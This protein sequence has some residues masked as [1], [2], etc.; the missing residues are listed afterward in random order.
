MVAKW[1]FLCSGILMLVGTLSSCTTVHFKR[2]TEAKALHESGDA[3]QALALLDQITVDISGQK[4]WDMRDTTA[5]YKARIQQ[6]RIHRSGGEH[7]AALAPMEQACTCLGSVAFQLRQV[8]SSMAANYARMTIECLDEEKELLRE[9]GIPES[10]WN[11]H[12]TPPGFALASVTPLKLR[13]EETEVSENGAF[14]TALAICPKPGLA[15]ADEYHHWLTVVRK[16][17]K[18]G[19]I[20]DRMGLPHGEAVMTLSP[21]KAGRQDYTVLDVRNGILL[22][23]ILSATPEKMDEHRKV[24]LDFVRGYTLRSESYEK[25][26]PH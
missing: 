15:T 24:F 17:T 1:V 6:G 18:I 23:F 26:G 9:L 21:G 19:P 13:F 4:T 14:I 16:K 22:M 10:S 8:R 11:S 20:V 12:T 2:I 5:F 7:D 25:S 3:E